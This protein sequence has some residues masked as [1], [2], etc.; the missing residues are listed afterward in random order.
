MKSES[1]EFCQETENT[2]NKKGVYVNHKTKF[3]QKCEKYKRKDNGNKCSLL[4]LIFS[5]IMRLHALKPQHKY[6]KR[7]SDPANHDD[8]LKKIMILIC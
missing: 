7:N 8:N 1:S 2:S 3:P 5:F 6:L 4:F